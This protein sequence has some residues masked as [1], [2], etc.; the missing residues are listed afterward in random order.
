MKKQVKISDI[1]F[2]DKFYLID[3]EKS[4][5]TKTHV[6][7]TGDYSFYET[8][9]KGCFAIINNHI[10]AMNNDCVVYIDVPDTR[11][12]DIKVGEK[13][14]IGSNIYIKVDNHMTHVLPN[15][16]NPCIC[17]G[18]SFLFNCADDISVERI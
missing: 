4:T 3:Y 14:K 7:W 5:Y 8:V 10:V 13:F 2:G 12:K 1:K 17:V 18:N 16:V 9:K 11:Y 6:T 15:N